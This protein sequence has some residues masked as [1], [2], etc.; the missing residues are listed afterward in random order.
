MVQ[1]EVA[2]RLA[3][4]PGSKTYGVPSV[5]A[6]WYA[7][8]RLAGTVPRSVFWPVPNVDSGLV[9]LTRREPPVTTATREEVFAVIDAAFAQRRKTLRAA[10]A[11]WAGGRPRRR[12]RCGR[13]D[14]DPQARGEQLLSVGTFAAIAA[15]ARELTATGPELGWCH[16]LA[17][18]HSPVGDSPCPG[19]GQ[20]RAAGRTARRRDGFHALSTV[21][22]A[23]GLYD[24]V[25]VTD[26]RPLV[27][28]RHRPVCRPRPRR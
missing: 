1:L 18:A 24:E 7:D 21:F 11:T 17:P 27:G 28:H 5:K 9:E 4:G 12:R 8:A 13:R 25:T 14:V 16:D 10:L 2:E 3:A 26:R 20:P 22:M 6:A 15:L 19:E 23:V